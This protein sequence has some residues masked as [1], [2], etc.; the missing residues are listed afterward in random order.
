MLS[1]PGIFRKSEVQVTGAFE[2]WEREQKVYTP[3]RR[4]HLA[5]FL[6]SASDIQMAVFV[7]ESYK[8]S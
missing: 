3:V 7:Q 5:H 2:M 4:I 8:V 6:S 1:L